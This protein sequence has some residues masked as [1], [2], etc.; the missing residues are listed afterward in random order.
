[1]RSLSCAAAVTTRRATAARPDAGMSA[2][3]WPVRLTD[4]PVGIRPLR[5]R[6]GFRW[7][8]VRRTNA[9]WLA[10]W[11]VTP[12]GRSSPDPATWSVYLTALRR[13]REQA[14]AGQGL[15][16]AVTLH[17]RFVGQVTVGNIGAP[18]QVSP[19][20]GYWIDER[21]AGLGVTPSALA[22]VAD[23]CFGAVGI[24]RLEANVRPE[25]L[26]SRRVVEKLGF[27]LEG[28]RK[29]F[30]HVDGE[31]RDHLCYVIT[32]EDVGDGGMLARWHARQAARGAD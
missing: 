16:L 23:H 1:M 15:P 17:G 14:Q 4:G 18:V 12:P 13:L 7:I 6:D 31:W 24:R 20:V 28:L 26:A 2:P 22:M 21:Y 5:L 25:N 19:Y 9:E 3:G 29:R 27:R 10:P 11:E 8:E 30:L 32:P